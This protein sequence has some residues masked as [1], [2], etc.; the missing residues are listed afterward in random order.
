MSL[1]RSLEIIA[2]VFALGAAGYRAAAV[3]QRGYAEN[4][5]PRDIASYSAGHLQSDVLAFANQLG[6]GRFHLIARDWAHALN[7]LPA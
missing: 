2:G 3:D 1:G 5:R 4:A 7:S 6:A